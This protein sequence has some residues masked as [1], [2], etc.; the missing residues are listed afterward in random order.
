MVYLS[1]MP[2]K[3]RNIIVNQ[4]LPDYSNTPCVEGSALS[5]RKIAIITTSGLH[6]RDENVFT[7]GISEYRIIPDNTDMS[8]LIMSYVSTNFERCLPY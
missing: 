3:Q 5:E 2:E 7:P 4:D 8:D 1:D 6:R